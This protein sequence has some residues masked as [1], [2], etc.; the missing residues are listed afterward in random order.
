MK[1]L[2]RGTNWIGDSIM[3]IPAMRELR[4]LFPDSHITL[5]TRSL[6]EGL[7]RN[8][9][10]LDGIISFERNRWPITDVY[11]NA[12]FLKDEGFDLAILFPN[13][14]E[15]ALVPFLARVPIRI[16]YN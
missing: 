3:S 8:A 5:H 9:A 16:G 15:S 10:F 7:F 6:C 11:D 4:R 2:V 12:R 14:F 13:S 1:I